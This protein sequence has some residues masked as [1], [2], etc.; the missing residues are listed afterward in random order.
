MVDAQK[1]LGPTMSAI[2]RWMGNEI[3]DV[4]TMEFDSVIKKSEIIR[5]VGKGIDLEIIILSEVTK[6]FIAINFGDIIFSN[7]STLH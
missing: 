6:H 7:N 4:H 1:V 3:I 2:N 5:F